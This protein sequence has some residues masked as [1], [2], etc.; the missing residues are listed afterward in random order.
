MIKFTCQACGMY[1]VLFPLHKV[2][3]AAWF[4]WGWWQGLKPYFGMFALPGMVTVLLYVALDVGFVLLGWE[5]GVAHWAH[6]G[7]FLSGAGA[8][9]LLLISRIAFTGA[10]LLSVTLGKHA[11]ALIGRP[12]SRR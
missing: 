7:G 2:H 8:A 9:A 5:S 10:D 4:R 1:V 3:M 11:W 12:A 6:L